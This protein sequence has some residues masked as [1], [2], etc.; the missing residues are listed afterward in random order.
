MGYFKLVAVLKYCNFYSSVNSAKEQHF[1]SIKV[2]NYNFLPLAVL[3]TH[4]R[5]S[6]IATPTYQFLKIFRRSKESNFLK[7]DCYLPKKIVLFALLK[8]LYK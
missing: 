8:A 6:I 1:L 5:V 2:S 4:F 7:S 3:Q